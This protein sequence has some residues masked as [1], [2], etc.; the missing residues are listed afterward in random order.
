MDAFKLWSRGIEWLVVAITA[1]VLTAINVILLKPA[2][3]RSSSIRLTLINSIGLCWLHWGWGWSGFPLVATYI[4]TLGTAF[5]V[6]YRNS[7]GSSGN[8]LEQAQN[9]SRSRQATESLETITIVFGLLLLISRAIWVADVTIQQLG[10][11]IGVCGW[12]L[13]WLSRQANQAL[14]EWGGTALLLVGGLVS[15]PAVCPWQALVISGLGLWLLVDRFR[16]RW[17]QW[18]LDALFLVGLLICW[19]LWRIASALIPQIIAAIGIKVVQVLGHTFMPWA[20][21]G[22]VFLGYVV[23]TLWLATHLYRWQQPA[24]AQ[25]A[26]RL[27]LAL[28][29]GLALLSAPNPTMRVLNLFLS[30]LILTLVTLRRSG[31]KSSLIYLTHVTGLATDGAGIYRLLPHLDAQTWAGLLLVGMV[32]EWVLSVGRNWRLWRRSAWHLG[33]VLAAISYVL[34]AEV[35]PDAGLMILMGLTIPVTLTWLA[36]RRHF[37]QPQTAT[38]LSLAALIA[39]QP[40]TWL[41]SLTRLVTLGVATGLMLLNTRQIPRVV[42]AVHTV[43][44]SLAFVWAAIWQARAGDISP[45]LGINLLAGAVLTLWLLRSGTLKYLATASIYRKAMDGWAIALCSSELILLTWHSLEIYWRILPASPA[46]V[47]AVAITIGAIAYR[48]W[49]LPTDWIVYSLGWSLELLTAEVLGFTDGSVIYLAI[50]NVVLGLMTQLTG[51]WWQ[52]RAGMN[53]LP[54][55]WHVMPLFYGALGVALRWGTFQMWTGWSTLGVALI[56]IGVG[57]RQAEFKPLVYLA[58]IGVTLSAYE[59]LLYRLSQMPGVLGDRFI[60]MTVL[61][62]SLLYAYRVLSPWL[63]HYMV[64]TESE[65]K[66]AA[67]LHWALSSC[68]LS[69]AVFKSAQIQWLIGNRRWSLFDLLRHCARTQPLSL[70]GVRVLG[71]RWH[72]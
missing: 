23:L 6:F 5:L 25:H 14:W 54:N 26:E 7:G 22:V 37:P 31:P 16:Q 28:G 24:L 52:R 12:L 41:I 55:S 17:Q 8:F 72:H 70:Q 10:L 3:P 48:G 67:H 68:F 49:R 50:T 69:M 63:S 43:G 4:G 58:M 56:A 71:I 57:R 27:A 53:H 15:V 19:L 62:T 35:T 46:G 60:A 51:D 66:I 2:S 13:A 18:V 33:L 38:W 20:F 61:G 44:F 65:L 1:L 30:T 45:E 47:L 34:L 42:M 36:N 21:M 40:W 9:T 59:I 39:L 11:A 32:A 29:C 64:L